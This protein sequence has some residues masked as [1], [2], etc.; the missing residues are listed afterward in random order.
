[1]EMMSELRI[2][3][4]TDERLMALGFLLVGLKGIQMLIN[5]CFRILLWSSS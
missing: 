1:M 4:G 5:H 2:G 3:T